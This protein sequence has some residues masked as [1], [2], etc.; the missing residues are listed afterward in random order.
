MSD[1]RPQCHLLCRGGRCLRGRSIRGSWTRWHAGSPPFASAAGG[2]SSSAS[3][4]APAT[5]R[6]RS[7]T[8]ASSAR[9][10]SYAPTD[11]VSELT[12]RTNDDGWETSFSAWLE[13]S[14]LSTRDALL[15]FSV[16]GGSREHNVSVN[17]VRAMEARARSAAPRST[18]SSARPAARSPSWPTSRSSSSR[19]RRCARRWSSPS[20]PSSGTRW[21]R[22]PSW[23]SNR[24]TG[25]RSPP[26]QAVRAAAV[27]LDRD[28]VLNELVAGSRS[29]ARPS[30]R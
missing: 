20:R 10:E 26:P 15:V 19:R 29:P 22:T 9:I 17:L 23:P 7:T 13:V 12:A 6:T 14:R 21:S 28:G 4:A 1:R 27:F 25:S 16:G 30:R 18:A 24:A 3:A 11:N 8:S 5:P 2:C